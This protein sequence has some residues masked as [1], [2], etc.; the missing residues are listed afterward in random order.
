[1]ST[2][3]HPEL[4]VGDLVNYPWYAQP[5]RREP[6]ADSPWVAGAPGG[7][8]PYIR[9]GMGRGSGG[10]H[11][12]GG[13]GGGGH[14]GGTHGP[15]WGGWGGWGFRGYRGGGW[16]RWWGGSWWTWGPGGWS[17]WPYGCGTWGQPLVSP[18]PELVATAQGYLQQA[19]TAA[20]FDWTDGSTYLATSDG[21]I[22]ACVY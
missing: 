13:H 19:G 14:W 8:Q 11:G 21:A 2:A 22:R 9:F 7:Y 15:G 16:R 6:Y 18:P 1:M 17:L 10:G 4:R 5:G 20:S 3:A 12:G